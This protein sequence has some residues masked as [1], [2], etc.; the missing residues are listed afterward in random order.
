M[1]SK[2][3]VGKPLIAGGLKKQFREPC[4]TIAEDVIGKGVS[5]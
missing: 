2:K 5:S 3:E 4:W 1:N